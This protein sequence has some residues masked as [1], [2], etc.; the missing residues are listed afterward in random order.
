MSQLQIV[1]ASA[2]SGKTHRLVFEYLRLLLMHPENYRHTL[3]VT[4]T[5]KAT[6]EMK[7]RI[8]DEI[9]LLQHICDNSCTPSCNKISVHRQALT[10]QLK[11][12]DDEIALKARTVI[13]N[14]LH[15]YSQFSV[16]TIDS[17]FQQ[18]LRAFLKESGIGTTTRIELDSD[19][20]IQQ[21]VDRLL[22]ELDV[23]DELYR[24]LVHYMNEQ[25]AQGRSWN[26]SE[27]LTDMAS[28]LLNEKFLAL[29]AKYQQQLFKEDFRTQLQRDHLYAF[30]KYY[31]KF[32]QEKATE[33][34]NIIEE[35]NLSDDDFN[36]KSRGIVN[37]FRKLKQKNYDNLRIDPLYEDIT[38]WPHSKTKNKH[39]V[40]HALKEGG[41]HHCYQ[42]I[43][44]YIE[45]NSQ[46]YYDTLA[47]LK[48]I[49]TY[50]VL[51][52]VGRSI[53]NV[54][55]ENDIQLLSKTTQF[56]NELIGQNDAPFIYE[57]TGRILRHFII[58][59]FQDTSYIQWQNF[60]P[61]INECL[62]NNN[63]AMVVGD[64]K[65]S[66]YRWRNTDWSI[67]EHKAEEDMQAHGTHRTILDTNWRSLPEI[68]SFNNDFFGEFLVKSNESLKSLYSTAI[69]KC[70]KEDTGGGMVLIDVNLKKD[71][72]DEEENDENFTAPVIKWTIDKILRLLSIG[73][74]QKDI[75]ILVRE[76][77]E[78]VEIT[79]AINAFNQSQTNKIHVL[80]AETALLT[81][82]VA[83][84]LILE[85]FQYLLTPEDAV[86]LEALKIHFDQLHQTI[87]LSIAEK[88][89]PQI[90]PLL[91]RLSV[92]MLN[93]PLELFEEVIQVFHLNQYPPFLPYI[94]AFHNFL[95]EYC[96]NHTPQLRAFMDYWEHKKDKIAL[97]ISEEQDA[98]R[99]LTIH[100]SKGLQF[101]NVIIPYC[102]WNLKYRGNQAPLLWCR[103]DNT[104]LES[105]QYI[106]I[107]FSKDLESTSFVEEYEQ[108]RTRYFIDNINL[109][110]VAFTRP[111]HHLFVYVPKATIASED[112][113][114]VGDWVYRYIKN[115]KKTQEEASCL[116]FQQGQL[117]NEYHSHEIET[118]A[119]CH[120]RHYPVYSPVGRIK[121]R[122]A[123]GGMIAPSMQYGNVMHRLFQH[124]Y[125]IDDI[126]KAVEIVIAE[127]LLP[128]RERAAIIAWLKDL[129]T[130][131]PFASWF[132][133]EWNIYTE[134]TVIAPSQ[135]PYRPDRVMVNDQQ[136]I[137]IDYKFGTKELSSYKTQLRTYMKFLARMGYTPVEGYLWYVQSGKIEKIDPITA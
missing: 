64:V 82:C 81:Q 46:K 24:W 15:N 4:F 17:F 39:Q 62:A 49:H 125:Y 70:A 42:S 10:D 13:Y 114:T 88:T 93:N 31:E 65:Q 40:I 54:L 69:Q 120:F 61:L 97:E 20:V 91:E 2:G 32:L 122:S 53:D 55:R 68:V 27:K 74:R 33:A 110:Y 8:I 78:G 98:V 38:N 106:P 131:M 28:E 9:S 5:N 84:N 90:E 56:I 89:D 41:L 66:I 118:H 7:S 105:L 124:I 113:K 25:I 123:F 71:S 76:R 73:Y 3:A 50:G 85:V 100:K 136:A 35:Y 60:R 134:A 132:S 72:D 19:W 133:K 80:S 117:P 95:Y 37:F 109:L 48:N 121:Q 12:A 21:A 101:P 104:P 103:A 59:E 87:E 57:K 111:M 26:V 67:L 128:V 58:D 127:G 135:H 116:H 83:I 14:I 51:A 18:V 115:S 47:I 112:C 77:K 22:L 99:I 75:A 30:K 52:D 108:E 107:R 45:N 126:E 94:Q 23:N 36:G 11:I 1:E 137:V 79:E 43:V 63:F 96:I 102:D 92:L 6:E 34:L 29:P 129:L 44:S 130:R 16:M 119:D 86:N